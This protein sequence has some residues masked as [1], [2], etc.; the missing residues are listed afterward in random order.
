MSFFVEQEELNSI[1]TEPIISA[2]KMVENLYTSLF[3][4]T[5]WNN[6]P[7][8]ITQ[9][10]TSPIIYENSSRLIKTTIQKLN[11]P[12]GNDDRLILVDSNQIVCI[13]S[14]IINSFDNYTPIYSN[15]IGVNIPEAEYALCIAQSTNTTQANISYDSNSNKIVV[16][17]KPIFSI[18]N[19]N[20]TVG[21]LIYIHTLVH[22]GV[23]GYL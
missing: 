8:D 10:S 13:D 3:N 16:A 15:L 19:T 2:T 12:N 11:Y 4:N 7:N 17:C 18:I 9:L 23:G 22:N 6:I 21:Y 1:Y 20:I 14:N 5:S